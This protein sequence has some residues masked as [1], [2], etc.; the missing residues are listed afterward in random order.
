MTIDRIYQ[1]VPSTLYDGIVV[2]SPH[3]LTLIKCTMYEAGFVSGLKLLAWSARDDADGPSKLYP[4]MGA[5]RRA[6]DDVPR[7]K[8]CYR[9]A[10]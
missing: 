10:M 7:A 8:K 5:V 3:G 6:G 4:V 9:T 1:D 2:E